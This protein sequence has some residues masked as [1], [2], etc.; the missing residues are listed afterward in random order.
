MIN[1]PWVA[2]L[3]AIPSVWWVYYEL[4][5][6]LFNGRMPLILHRRVTGLTPEYITAGKG[7]PWRKLVKTQKRLFLK[8]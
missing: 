2:P 6:S 5:L 7:K 1:S 3:N 8:I 4:I